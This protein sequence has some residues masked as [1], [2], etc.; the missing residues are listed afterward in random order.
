MNRKRDAEIERQIDLQT[1][2]WT[3]WH[4]DV[5][6]DDGLTYGCMWM[7]RQFDKQKAGQASATEETA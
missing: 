4:K 3:D 5:Q 6:M 1:E 2:R 7:G